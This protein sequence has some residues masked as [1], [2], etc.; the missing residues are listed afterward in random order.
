MNKDIV[1]GQ[2]KQLKGKVREKW[3][4][5]TDDEVDMIKGDAQ[6][7]AGLVQERYGRTREQAEKEVNEFYDQH[8]K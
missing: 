7:L 2:W 8:R 5:L 1:E 4:D 6:R 3:G